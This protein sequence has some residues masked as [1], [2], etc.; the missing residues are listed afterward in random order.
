MAGKASSES[1]IPPPPLDKHTPPYAIVGPFQLSSQEI[2]SAIPK[3]IGR[4]NRL[5]LG[6]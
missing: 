4:P 5:T 6:G 3:A 1:E 2:L